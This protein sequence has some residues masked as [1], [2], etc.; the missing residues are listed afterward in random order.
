M[1]VVAVELVIDWE[2]FLSAVNRERPRDLCGGHRQSSVVGPVTISAGLIAVA[3]DVIRMSIYPGLSNDVHSVGS[4]VC[5]CCQRA[6]MARLAFGDL[7]CVSLKFRGIHIVIG[8]QRW[9]FGMRRTVATRAEHIA[10]PFAV[11]VQVSAGNRNVG[12]GGKGLIRGL[13]PKSIAGEGSGKALAGVMAHLAR[14][15]D[16]P[17]IARP[18]GADIADIA[19]A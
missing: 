6:R 11:A 18:I 5:G 4:A 13:P 17:G 16:H 19:V 15:F 8:L 3:I 12:I 1:T 10:V 14:G 7:G 9:I 2:G